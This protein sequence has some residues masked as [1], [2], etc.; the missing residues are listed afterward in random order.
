[1]DPVVTNQARSESENPVPQVPGWS[2]FVW[3]LSGFAI[4]VITSLTALI[5][6]IYITALNY[7]PKMVNV[8][9]SLPLF[10]G[11]ITGPLIGHFSDNTRS[12]WGRRKPWI[13]GGV[14]L[15]AVLGTLFW[16]VPMSDGKWNWGF[17]IFLS[18]MFLL[19]MNVGAA[20][21]ATA[22]GALGFEMTTDYN[23]RTHLFKWRSY[24]GAI[25]GFIGRWFWPNVHTALLYWEG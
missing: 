5:N 7:N 20:S 19:L 2:R 18:V 10:A 25:A 4:S 1:M 12:R 21:Y 17:F 16:F 22:V 23:E 13:L 8:A 6:Q 11:F 24:T 15:S 3:S 9:K 14:I